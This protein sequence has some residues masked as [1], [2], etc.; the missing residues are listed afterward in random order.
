MA[1][2]AQ[3]DE[4]IREVDGEVVDAALDEVIVA[5]DPRHGVHSPLLPERDA[6]G[7]HREPTPEEVFGS[8]DPVEA[9]VD[10]PESDLEGADGR[11]GAA[12]R[13]LTRP[14]AE[15]PE[16]VFAE[17]AVEQLKAAEAV[18]EAAPEDVAEAEAH[19][20]E[21]E[22]RERDAADGVSTRTSG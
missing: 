3:R 5:G 18:G 12:V 11:R 22:A 1:E 9:Q 8:P 21:L 4:Q 19:R 15:T 14:V 17:D 2:N 13:T 16:Q 20:A 6:L 10:L 7:V